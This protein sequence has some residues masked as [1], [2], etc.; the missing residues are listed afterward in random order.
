MAAT[1]AASST[2][3]DA[4]S[5]G[6]PSK[7]TATADHWPLTMDAVAGPA[8]ARWAHISTSRRLDRCHCSSSPCKLQLYF[9]VGWSV[10]SGRRETSFFA[11][12]PTARK[13]EGGGN[14]TCRHGRARCDAPGAAQGGLPAPAAC[15]GVSRYRLAG[16]T[17]KGGTLPATRGLV[18]PPPAKASPIP[19]LNES[20]V[21]P[22]LF[23][24][25]PIREKAS[26]SRQDKVRTYTPSSRRIGASRRLN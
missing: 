24:V 10:H 7:T 17:R 5:A 16:T 15:A 18:S 21:I 6:E 13:N 2:T 20:P 25:L 11:L 1:T 8:K 14:A 12:E 19:E 9:D 3:G 22:A 23:G 26:K 4:H